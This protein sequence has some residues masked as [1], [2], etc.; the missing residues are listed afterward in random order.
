MRI[1]S[2]L[3]HG[4]VCDVCWVSYWIGRILG[5]QYPESL[6]IIVT[7]G[8]PA[9]HEIFAMQGQKHS[10]D[11]LFAY[12]HQLYCNCQH[13]AFQVGIYCPS[14][15]PVTVLLQSEAINTPASRYHMTEP[16][17]QFARVSV[18]QLLTPKPSV[19]SCQNLQGNPA[20]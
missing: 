1:C 14:S 2:L 4:K 20:V 5:L 9:R 17:V 13:V 15:P 12:F 7:A 6:E 8:Q 19:T 16:G 18:V 3:C 11:R 10:L